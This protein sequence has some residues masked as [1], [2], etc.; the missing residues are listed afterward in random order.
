MSAPKFLIVDGY[1]TASRDD[2]HKVGMTLAGELYGKL[3]KRHLPEAEFEIWY[4]SDEDARDISDAELKSYT[5]VLWPGCNLTIY[6][7]DWRVHKHTALMR[8][9]LDAGLPGFGSCWAIQVAAEIAGGESAVCKNGRE[10]GMGDKILLNDAGRVHPMFQGKPPVFS[11]F[12]SHE[13]EVVRLP[14]NATLLASNAWA[15]VQAAAFDFNGTPFWGLQ[16][17]PEYNLAEMAA[18]ILARAAKLIKIGYF[19]DQED[20]ERYAARLAELAADPG[21]IDLRWQLKIDGDILDDATRE[22]EFKNWIEH[23]IR[24]RLAS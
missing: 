17:H 23:V 14:E 20:A 13:D 18:L 8:R 15:E 3:L 12:M 24:P 5:A 4:S 10:M 19:R 16:Y 7:D 11:A 1:T 6:H 21:R 2:F 22:C 9:H